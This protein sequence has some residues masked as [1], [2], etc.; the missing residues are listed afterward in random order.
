M[1]HGHPD[2]GCPTCGHETTPVRIDDLLADGVGQLC[3][4]CGRI[5]YAERQ[6]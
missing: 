5:V 6:R 4:C 2:G 3:R 1:S